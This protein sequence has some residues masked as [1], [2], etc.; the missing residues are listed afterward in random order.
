MKT[1]KSISDSALYTKKQALSEFGTLGKILFHC[2][3]VKLYFDGE[4]WKSH[5]VWFHP[6]TW[7]GYLIILG[8]GIVQS[9]NDATILFRKEMFKPKEKEV[10]W[11]KDAK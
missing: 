1:Q 10:Y 8:V 4:C 7:V 9:A 11:Y 6:A 3:V 5:A 2:G